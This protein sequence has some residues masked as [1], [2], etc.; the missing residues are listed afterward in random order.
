MV[1]ANDWMQISI[2]VVVV[3]LQKKKSITNGTVVNNVA[4]GINITKFI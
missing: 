4:M 3:L 2:F 1:F